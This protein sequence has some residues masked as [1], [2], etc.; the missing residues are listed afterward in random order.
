MPRKMLLSYLALPVLLALMLSACSMLPA[1]ADMGPK[2]D[3]EFRV[4]YS[5]PVVAVKSGKLMQSDK[6]DFSDAKPL[7]QLGPQ[8]FYYSEM[9]WHALAYGFKD[10]SK[11]VIQFADK[12]RSSNV[13][14]KRGFQACYNVDV[15]END[16]VVTEDPQ[17]VALAQGGAQS[18]LRRFLI[19]GVITL[20]VEL[21]LGSIYIAIRKKP[22]MFLWIVVANLVTLP[23]TWLVIPDIIPAFPQEFL[24]AAIFSWLAEAALFFFL[25]RGEMRWW[26]AV[27]LSLVL[28]AASAVLTLMV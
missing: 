27:I 18:T 26:V 2:P 4:K 20:V 15:R 24:V 12:E 22:R 7:P 16:L 8:D 19:A 23:I 25:M 28:N 5:I 10:Y 17:L 21:V 1:F 9:P 11:L 3:M 14:R 6:E 13:F